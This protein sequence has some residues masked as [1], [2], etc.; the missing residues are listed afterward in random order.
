MS[1]IRPFV[2]ADVSSVATLHESLFAE[3]SHLSMEKR[4]RYLQQ[5]FLENP[6]Y[7]DTLPSLVAEEDSGRVVGFMGVLP[8]RMS[9]NGRPLTAAVMSQ[10]MVASDHRGLTGFRLLKTALAGRQDL[11]MTDGASHEAVKIWK[12]VGGTDSPLHSIHWTRPLRP[13]G[14]GLSFVSPRAPL[15]RATAGPVCAVVDAI[16]ARMRQSPFRFTTPTSGE[17][18]TVDLLLN[19]ADQFVPRAT[20][21][22]EYDCASLEWL[23]E[24]ARQKASPGDLRQ[25]L[26]RNADNEVIGWYIYYLRRRSSVSRRGVSCEV[27]QIA[28]RPHRLGEVLEN[29]LYNAWREGALDVSGRV[30]LGFLDVLRAKHCLFHGRGSPVL[31]HSR[32]RELVDAIRRGDAFLTRLDGEW[33]MSFHDA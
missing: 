29:L 10:F 15:L 19:Y 2:L 1:R 16:A 6:W 27:L 33:W 4:R 20:L 18:L 8:R 7:D 32:C 13:L 14:Y 12:A 24:V 21:R 25:V 9:W 30:G 3:T 22:P 31:V 5:V 28:G 17:A 26:V 11:S 23:L